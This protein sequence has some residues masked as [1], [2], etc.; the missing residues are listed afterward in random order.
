MAQKKF[1][2]PQKFHEYISKFKNWGPQKLFKFKFGPWVK[3]L[4]SPVCHGLRLT[5]RVDYFKVNFDHFWIKNHFL[6]QLGHYKKLARAKNKSPITKLDCQFFWCAPFGYLYFQFFLVEWTK[7]GY[8][9]QFH[10][11]FLHA[12][13]VRKHVFVAKI[14]YKIALCSFVIFGAKILYEKRMRN[15]LLKLTAGINPGM[16]VTPFSSCIGW[17]DN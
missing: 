5:R 6:R 11:H 7:F 1:S 2:A 9:C 16:S 3:S 15:T 13:F 10:Q 17:D 8:R 4:V 12:F 14:L